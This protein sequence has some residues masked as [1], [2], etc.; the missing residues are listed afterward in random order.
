MLEGE[1]EE[2]EE[3]E[4]ETWSQVKKCRLIWRVATES[5]LIS[6]TVERRMCCVGVH[7][8]LTVSIV[9]GLFGAGKCDF[10][11]GGLLFTSSS[12]AFYISFSTES[13]VVGWSGWGWR[14]GQRFLISSRSTDCSFRHCVGKD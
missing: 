12:G 5:G 1:E 13:N 10:V 11:G 8:P 9:A 7:A 6:R 14:R 2:E 3:E 4:E